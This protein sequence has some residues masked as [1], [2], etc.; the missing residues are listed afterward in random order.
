[1]PVRLK[2]TAPIAPAAILVGDPGRALLLA[3]ELLAQPK[4]SNHARGLWGYGGRTPE[5]E[6]LT[7]QA[8][9]MGGPSAALVLADLAELGVERAI[10][11][12][13]CVAFG[14]A[15]RA[16]ELLAVEAALAVG[17]SAASFGVPAGETVAPDAELHGRLARALAGDARAV[18][19][20]SLD[21]MPT[22]P[23]AAAG[24]GAADMQSLATL[25]TARRLGIAAAALLIATETERE[26][27]LRGER[28][29]EVAARAGRAAA[30]A[31]SNPQVEG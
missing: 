11:V 9:G 30:E 4:M 15:A 21:T 6:E 24:A 19:V 22:Q 18:T 14:A 13:T 7:V 17:G 10:R 2:P 16:G 12:G 23:R 31:L 29:E 1:M 3:Q 25:A 8:T 27:P 28:L 5:G 20:A 26:E